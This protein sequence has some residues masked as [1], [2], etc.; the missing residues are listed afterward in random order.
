[1]ARD[2]FDNS[3]EFFNIAEHMGET[4][5]FAPSDHVHGIKTVHGEKDAILTDVVI[6]SQDNAVTY[7]AM[8]FQGALIARL[9]RSLNSGRPALGV[10]AKGEARKGQNEPW[11][12]HAADETGVQAARDFLAENP[13]WLET[14]KEASSAYKANLAALAQ[15]QPLTAHNIATAPGQVL[16]SQQAA[17]MYGAAP[18]AAYAPQR[19]D[20]ATAGDDPWA[21]GQ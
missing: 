6:L 2:P 5:L 13:D 4:L 20:V 15:G 16:S 1:M 7:D 14:L 8:I 17:A 3:G 19:S 11:E 9:R 18:Q 12:L 10:L 21:T